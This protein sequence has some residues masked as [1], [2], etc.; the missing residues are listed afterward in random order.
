MRPA[1]GVLT[2][3]ALA[4][5]AALGSASTGA[6]STEAGLLVS[7]TVTRSCQL[8]AG[9]LTFGSYDPVSNNATIP[10]DGETILTVTC[11]KGTPAA[12]ALGNGANESGGVRFMKS[13]GDSL[14]YALFQDA[15]RGQPWGDQT[16]N[17]LTLA[18]SNGDPQSIYVYG[19]I[20]PNQDVPI[21]S[22]TDSIVATVHF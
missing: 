12:I 16:G 5:G 1:R 2:V 14:G 9:P 18:P 11:T 4:V 6:Q 21:G 17:M 7:A 3:L 19:R 15:A 22:Y 10:L 20:P 8:E 13:G